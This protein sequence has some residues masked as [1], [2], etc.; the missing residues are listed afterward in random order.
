M[1][2]EMI[3]SYERDKN[4]KRIEEKFGNVVSM[5]I[6]RIKW[7]VSGAASNAGH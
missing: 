2:G 4:D 3:Y 1:C 5:A 7:L 6:V